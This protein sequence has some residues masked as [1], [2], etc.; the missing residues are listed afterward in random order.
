MSDLERLSAA[1]DE[2][3]ARYPRPGIDPLVLSEAYDVK[4]DWVKYYPGVGKPGAYAL[5][6]EK[7]RLLKVGKS[8]GDLGIRLGSYFRHD[9][10][11]AGQFARPSPW[12]SDTDARFIVAIELPPGH[13][14]EAAAIEEFL[15]DR[16]S[17]PNR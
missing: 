5:F 11:G 8:S 3:N 15:I 9:G 1:L 6:D 17:P 12:K 7:W 16:L 4:T 2:L 10:Q 14:F 13:A